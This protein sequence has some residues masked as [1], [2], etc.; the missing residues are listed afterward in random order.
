MGFIEC[1]SHLLPFV[2]DG[3]RSKDDCLNVLDA[4]AKAG[5]DRVV[6]TPHLYNPM[7]TTRIQNIRPMFSWASEEAGTRGIELILGSETYVGGMLDPQ[8]LPFLNN[9]VLLEVDTQ[10]EPLFLLH[11]AFGLRK[12][13]HSVILAHVERYRWFDEKSSVAVK[14]REMGVY[15]QCNVDGVEKGSADRYLQSGLVDIIAGDNH[16]D[17]TLP[18]RLAALLQSYPAV[19]Q[20]MEN[21]FYMR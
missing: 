1:H 7:V 12:R 18:A 9:F 11:H 13:G 5:F 3:V 14:L 10:T 8:V 2:D 4:Y 19:A 21:L 20:R 16:G 6:V 15:F 17:E